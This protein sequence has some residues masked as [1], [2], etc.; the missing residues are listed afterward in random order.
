MD[1]GE[2]HAFGC[3]SMHLMLHIASFGLLTSTN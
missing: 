2:I 3:R 1:A